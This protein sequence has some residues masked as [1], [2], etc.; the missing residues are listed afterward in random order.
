M[1]HY[2]SMYD[3]NYLY[4]FDLGDRDVVVEIAKVEQGKLQ[5]PG[6]TKTTKK[7]VVFFRGRE[8]GPGL[9][10]NATNG[11]TIAKLYGND[12][13]EWIGKAVTLYATT[14]KFGPETVECIRVRPSKP[15]AKAVQAPASTLPPVEPL[16]EDGGGK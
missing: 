1:A 5:Q 13:R 11:K 10:L 4:S 15:A 3:R 12:T 9:V 7:P 8:Q 6:T 14:T 16:A 2:K